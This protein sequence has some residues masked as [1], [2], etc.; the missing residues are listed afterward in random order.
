MTLRPMLASG[1]T[2]LPPSAE[3]RQWAYEFKWDGVRAI[4]RVHAG[5]LTLLSRNDRDISASYPEV[6]K[7][8]EA[9]GGQ[10]VLDDTVLDD[11]VL[12]G[13]LVALDAA[14][15]P[16]F[17]ALQQRMH[18]TAPAA[19]VHLVAAVPVT[20]LLFDILLLRGRSLLSEP[21]T[22]RREAL[23]GLALH[24]PSWQTP[25][26]FHGDGPAVLAASGSLGLEG[27]LAKRLDSTYQPGLRS[28][29]WRKIKN[30]RT[31]D[32]VIGGWKPGQGRRRGLPGS[33]LLGI[34]EPGGLR[35]IGKVG[36]GFTDRAL[37]RIASRLEDLAQVRSPFLDVPRE[38]ARDAR[39]VQPVL[40]AEVEFG[41]W[42]AEGRLR[43]P[44]WRGLREDVAVQDV[45]RADV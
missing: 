5:R 12:D 23:Q 29:Y 33:L 17:G 36:T 20:Y 13:E 44:S 27:V 18:V 21:Y 11:T 41:E 8:A 6:L 16:S 4:G 45:R 40:V 28:P 10:P 26:Y 34:P 39:W 37:E 7:L 19:L 9:A 14:G 3:D 25:P 31:Q 38:H 1:A 24:G 2:T 15:R 35:Y 42:T 43:H 22:T 30:M 32:A